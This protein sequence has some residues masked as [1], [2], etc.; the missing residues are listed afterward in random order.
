MAL[1]RSANLDPLQVSLHPRA[2][3]FADLAGWLRL[4][5]QQFW[6]GLSWRMS[7]RL[8]TRSSRVAERVVH[9]TGMRRSRYGTLIMCGFES[10]QSKR[11]REG[12]KLNRTEKGKIAIY[13]IYVCPINLQNALLSTTSKR[14][15]HCSRLNQ[16]L[17]RLRAFLGFP[18]PATLLGQGWQHHRFL[19][20]L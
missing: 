2:T 7:P 16:C 12:S 8:L 14:I 10:L 20:L 17:Q 5:G 15:K 11:A 1:L 3:P 9:A 13:I 18:P 4:F 6:K 19:C